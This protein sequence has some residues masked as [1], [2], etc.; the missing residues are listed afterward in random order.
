MKISY[1]PEA[2]V[3]TWESNSSGNIDYASENGNIIVHF[4]KDNVPVLVEVL[5]ASQV[6]K[7]SEQAVH[8]ASLVREKSKKRY[9]E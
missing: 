4:T 6:L 8:Q 1:D 7:Q 2:D 9:G 5:E 3:L